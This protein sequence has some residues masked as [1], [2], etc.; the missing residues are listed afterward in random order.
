[1]G[2]K[3]NLL[4][5]FFKKNSVQAADLKLYGASGAAQPPWAPGL[6]AQDH[7]EGP[8]P[9]VL[10]LP[11]LQAGRAPALR[12]SGSQTCRLAS[13]LTIKYIWSPRVLGEATEVCWPFQRDSRCPVCF[14]GGRTGCP[15][16]GTGEGIARETF[17]NQ[18]GQRQQHPEGHGGGVPAFARV[19]CPAQ[20]GP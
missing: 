1:M 15:Q 12:C 9:Q 5:L 10:W 18:D 3:E 19:L 16:Q 20:R 11:D 6:E 13:P 17:C 8:G 7:G 14:H 2:G 4:I